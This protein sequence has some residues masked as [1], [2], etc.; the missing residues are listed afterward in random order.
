MRRRPRRH[1]TW[2]QFAGAR[3]SRDRLSHLK[4]DAT[5]EFR[6]PTSTGGDEWV[7]RTSPLLLRGEAQ[8]GPR[9]R[10]DGGL[11]TIL[12]RVGE[13]SLHPP[14][15]TNQFDCRNKHLS[16]GTEPFGTKSPSWRK[17]K[18]L[19]TD[20]GPCDGIAD[21]APSIRDGGQEAPCRTRWPVEGKDLSHRPVISSSS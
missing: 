13:P 6:S 15:V 8:T 2:A 3:H 10:L 17:R 21:L 7:Q 5:S 12:S 4:A 20:L 19:V 11:V 1:A 16:S 14:A 18:P 9:F